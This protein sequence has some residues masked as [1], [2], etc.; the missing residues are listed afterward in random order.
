MRDIYKQS[1]KVDDIVENDNEKRQ[2]VENFYS[3]WR[4]IVWAVNS[5]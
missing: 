2:A 5:I 1:K 4:E 3:E